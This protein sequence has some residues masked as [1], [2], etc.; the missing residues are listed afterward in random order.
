MVIALVDGSNHV[1]A[2]P[3][4]ACPVLTLG[5][6]EVYPK[7]DLTLF[8]GGYDER[9]H[10]NRAIKQCHNPLLKAEVHHYRGLTSM[11]K[12]LEDCLITLEHHWGE[13]AAIKLSCI[14]RLKMANM[15]AHIDLLFSHY[16]TFPSQ[17]STCF[18]HT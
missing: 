3:L 8:N 15:L 17:T 13:L 14:W 2:A 18:V 5:A 1:Y 6:C 16:Y 9:A 7:E 12:E 10:I 4:Y 11:L